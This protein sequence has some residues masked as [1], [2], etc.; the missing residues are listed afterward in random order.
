[1]KTKHLNSAKFHSLLNRKLEKEQ[2]S[3]KTCAPTM[4][5]RN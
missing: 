1:M 5:C 3:L 2:I 4:I